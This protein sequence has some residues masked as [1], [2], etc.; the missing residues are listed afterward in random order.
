[1]SNEPTKSGGVKLIFKDDSLKPIYIQIAEWLEDEIINGDIE[2][3]EQV[4][5]TN[6]FASMYNVN[7]ATV[8]KGLNML[9]N[10]DILYKKRGIGMFVKTGA[11][12][13]LIKKRKDNFFKDYIE[14]LIFEA[15]KLGITTDELVELIKERVE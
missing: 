3:E 12:D 6:Q 8:G 14:T 9:V 2:E 15:K 1:M 13:L 11:K 5:S 10:E 4:L 7:P